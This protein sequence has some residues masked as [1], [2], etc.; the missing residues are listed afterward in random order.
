MPPAKS[1]AA[2]LSNVLDRQEIRRNGNMAWLTM[3]PAPT[4]SRPIYLFIATQEG[5]VRTE[6]GQKA[7]R[8]RA[9]ECQS[10]ANNLRGGVIARL[11]DQ[12]S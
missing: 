8:S 10:N 1:A 2:K 9:D 6:Q 5:A 11:A 12:V 7:E 4:Q 3:T